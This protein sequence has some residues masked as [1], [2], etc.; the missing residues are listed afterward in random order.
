MKSK[1]INLLLIAFAI[2]AA[3]YGTAKWMSNKEPSENLAGLGLSNLNNIDRIELIRSPKTASFIKRGKQWYLNNNKVNNEFG[4]FLK[5]L[6]NLKV[7]QV[8]SRNSS[9]YTNFG[10]DEK[11]GKQ[12]KFYNKNK[13][14]KHAVFGNSSEFLGMYVRFPSDKNVYEISEDFSYELGKEPKDW[15]KTK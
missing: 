5:K 2:I 13:L 9:N 4:D 14:I 8:V 12:I 7:K 3:V 15:L 10:V 6:R 1:T 11:T